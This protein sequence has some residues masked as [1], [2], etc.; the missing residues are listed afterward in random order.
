MRRRL[1]TDGAHTVSATYTVALAG[2]PNVGK[3]TIFNALTGLHQHTGNWPGKTVVRACGRVPTDMC[4][5]ELVDLPGTYSL[6]SHSA[7][8]DV[9]R[10]FLAFGEADAAIVVCD[11]TCLSRS[12][13]L[14]L[15][16][17]EAVPRTVVCINLLDEAKQKGIHIDLTALSK[18]LGVPVVGTVARNRRSVK[19]LITAVNDTLNTHQMPQP[20]PLM[21]YT[22]A[23]ECAIAPLT[24][25]IAH[26][27]DVPGVARFYALRLLEGDEGFL[28]S[29]R[30]ALGTAL[31]AGA[32]EK[33]HAEAVRCLYHAGITDDGLRDLMASALQ[34]RAEEAC[35]RCMH[36]DLP[37]IHRRDRRIDRILT[38]RY[39]AYPVMLAFLAL[40]LWITVS[41]AA[42]PS[43]WLHGLFAWLEVPLSEGLYLLGTPPWL[44]SLL[45]DGLFRVSTWVIAVMLPPMAIFFPLF[46]FFEDIG[47]LP[48][49]A[50]NLD[51]PFAAC[52]ACGKQALTMCMGLGCNA[53]GVTGC[54]IMDSGR[55][56]ALA[57]I[58]NSFM[59][60]NGR[61]PTVIALLTLFVAGGAGISNSLAGA[62]LLT[63]AIAL[64]VG[65]TLLVT[66]L[67]SATVLRGEPSSFTL[68]LPPY[69]TPQIGRILIRSLLDRTLFVLGRAVAVA[70]PAGVVLWGMTYFRIDGVSLI[71]HVSNL[72]DPIGVFFGMDGAILTAFL[73]AIPAAELFI[74]VLLMIYFSLGTMLV[75]PSL[76]QLS[77]WLSSVGFD[78]VKALCTVIF[79][80]FHSPCSTT[81]ITVYKETRRPLYTLLSALIPTLVGLTLCLACRLIL[82]GI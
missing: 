10:D 80:L 59:P 44:F 23:V 58:T 69:R 29:A 62:G 54:R 17:M 78:T 20:Q 57:I 5:W 33:A 48:R 75:D 13:S 71:C 41:L 55:E 77:L 70:A 31:T 45:I 39:T 79:C 42:Y 25:A 76:A 3:S 8:E 46:T 9:A 16:V 53:V 35:D 61:F 51:R 56:R 63:L 67:L 6:L 27:T 65:M 24:Q 40:I 1:G 4:T 68:E 2:N 72:L 14:A 82:R 52:R 18:M 43:A 21:T 28:E 30:H 60:C 47:Y 22:D 11:A 73:F 19:Q 34:E 81:L 50:F 7:E 12:L 26:T 37:D 36:T 38:G 66:R 74:P 32:V 15:Q 64:C 49:I